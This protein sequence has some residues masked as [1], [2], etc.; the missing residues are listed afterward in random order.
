MAVLIPVVLVASLIAGWAVTVPLHR[1]REDDDGEG[2]A[3]ACPAA[4]DECGTEVEPSDVVP[5]RSWFGDGRACSNCGTPRGWSWIAPQVLLPVLALITTV[6]MGPIKS[7]PAY[8]V[9]VVV[10][11]MAAII[12][13][14]TMLIP[15]QLIW[16]GL[17]AGLAI[18]VAISLWIGDWGHLL[19]ALVG[20]V[21]YFGFL[22]LT[23]LISPRGMGFG[24][25]RLG[26]VM[27]LY[28]GWISWPLILIALILGSLVNVVQGLAINGIS[29]RKVPIPFGPALAMGA[30]VTI[31]A[32]EPILN[33]LMGNA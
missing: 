6:A 15:R 18:M 20:A 31:W 4:C 8:L 30:L 17:A 22:F 29:G 27:G 16:A 7:L 2:Y 25:V 3:V 14:R 1:F 9:L 13:L 24:D 19:G 26:A 33:L 21:G 12:D 11:V 5:F 23:W 28:L 10:L 32:H